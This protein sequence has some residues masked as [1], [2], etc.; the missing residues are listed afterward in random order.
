MTAKK[1]SLRLIEDSLGDLFGQHL[2]AH[3]EHALAGDAELIVSRKIEEEA[4]EDLGLIF[5]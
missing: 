5:K 4:E 1:Y 3:L 2:D